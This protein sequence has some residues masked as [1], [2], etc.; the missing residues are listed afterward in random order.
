MTV[1]LDRYA[2]RS[3]L[4]NLD[5]RTKILAIAAFVVSIALLHTLLP[6]A[7][8]L[9]VVL[10]MILISYI[11]PQHIFKHYALTTP[12]IL[13][14]TLALYLTF[15]LTPALAMFMRI[16]TSVLALILLASI[17]HFFDTLKALQRLHLPTLLINLLL[18]TYRYLFVIQDELHRM[19]QARYARGATPGTHLL[20]TKHMHLLSTTTGL[21]LIRA[22]ER[23]NRL[24]D[25]LQSRGYNGTIKTLTPLKFK[26]ID[27]LFLLSLLTYAILIVTIDWRLLPWPPS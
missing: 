15:G 21:I 7:I 18:F 16:T 25:A 8:G 20:D 9:L 3:P 13:I 11:P 26:P 24:Y 6:L 23:G 19:T 4:A 2:H 17:T 5:P 27:Y 10:I 14:T 22:T 12:F 1:I